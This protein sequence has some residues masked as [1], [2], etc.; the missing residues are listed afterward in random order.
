MMWQMW[1]VV[2]IMI[3][4]GVFVGFCDFRLG[5]EGFFVS[6]DSQWC[7]MMGLI[8]VFFFV[9]GI[10]VYSFFES[11]WYYFEKGDMVK[12]FQIMRRL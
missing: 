3:G 1:I 12:V 5:V 10:L 6:V 7:I 8:V 11:L 9:V 2:G 4:F